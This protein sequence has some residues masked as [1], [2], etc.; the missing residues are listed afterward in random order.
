MGLHEEKSISCY[1]PFTLDQTSSHCCP[2]VLLKITGPL[3]LLNGRKEKPTIRFVDYYK[4]RRL[5]IYFV[6]IN[7]ERFLISVDQKRSG[8]QDV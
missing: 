7:K 2:L 8:V 4:R 3:A 6:R 1:S 5:R